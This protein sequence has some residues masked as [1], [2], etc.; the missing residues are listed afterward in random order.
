ME[1]DNNNIL[2][3]KKAWSDSMENNPSNAF[4][5]SIIGYILESDVTPE[6]EIKLKQKVGKDFCWACDGDEPL[7]KIKKIQ[8]RKSVV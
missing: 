6:L 2:I 4:G 5:Y 1:E 8:D 7:Y 3:V